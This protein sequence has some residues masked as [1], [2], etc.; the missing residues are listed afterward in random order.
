[1]KLVI[2]GGGFCGSIL[3][4]KFDSRDE[5][6]TTLIDENGF[7]EFYPTL[8][9]LLT[10][11]D[12]ESKV[13]LRL[14]SFLSDTN[15]IEDKM[16]KITPEFVE[17]SAD[18]FKFD[19][20][21][22]CT[23]ANYPIRLD[24]TEDVFT[25]ND[26]TSSLMIHERLERSESVLIVG[27]GLIGV[28]VASEL[29]ADTDKKIC[30]VHPHSRLIERNPVSASKYAERFLNERNVRLIFNDKVVTNED[31]FYTEDDEMIK[32]DIAIWCGG[33]GFDV[34]FLHGFDGSIFSDHGGLKVDRYLRLEEHDKIFV[35][36]DITSV[37]EEKTGHNADRHARLIYQNII[38][39]S[40]GKRLSKYQTKEFPLLISLGRK[41]GIFT[42]RSFSFAGPLPALAKYILE[43]AAITRLRL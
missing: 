32:A 21:V 11:P 6:D 13:R 20:L 10:D 33:L 31:N 12:Y 15:L 9:R 34:S 24:N 3:A 43:R 28:E 27:G 39:H 42:F 41:D 38:K 23:G 37:S 4:K 8:P 36:G 40:K 17:T 22:I 25:V 5:F 19:Y 35:G 14:D 18:R 26:V 7:F 2:A 16:E 29:A 30:L 1:M